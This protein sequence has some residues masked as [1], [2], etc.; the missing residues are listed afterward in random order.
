MSMKTSNIKFKDRLDVQMKDDFMRKSVAN[1]QERMFTNRAKA[2]EKLG[3]WEQWRE[4]GMD[5]RNHVLENLDYYLHQL[6][7]NVQKNGGHVFFAR[8]AEEATDYVENIVKQKNAK[9]VVKSKSMVTEEIG[10]NK[11]I[12]RNECEVVETDLGEYILQV[13]D[14]DPPSHIVVPALHKNR[15]Q[16]RDVF[17]DKIG[18]DGSDDPEELTRYVRNY[19]RHDFLE[20]DIGITGCNFAVAESGTV[21]LVTN[22]G[23][24]RLATSLP[25]THIAVMGMERIVP[26]FEELDIVVSL[27]CRS[28]VGL[29]LTGYV[30]ALTG[31]REDEHC[32]G[33]EEFHLV[34]IDNGRSDILGSEF[35]DILRCVRCA[36]CVNTCPAYRHIGGQSYGSI[37]S[38]PIGAVLSPLLGGYDDFKDLPYAC[39]L[40][41]ACH[42]VCPVK[43]PLSDLLLKHRQ[44]MAESK[45]T[46]LMERATVGAFNFINARPLL[47][48]TTV[49]VGATVASGL[50]RNGKLPV[51]V[52]VSAWT[53]SRDLPDPDG[54]S[55][56][57]WF[58]N[59]KG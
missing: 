31:P 41:R 5:I 37:Y 48:D 47:W 16:I 56:R 44:K 7:E 23:N 27:L 54:Q 39:S 43:I 52:G 17:K 2:A 40:C 4:M 58:K 1:A 20:A 24:A 14:C 42:D 26:S 35:R 15:M 34:I 32:D 19:I 10:L 21:T 30:T 36:A 29:P 45:Q 11:I 57:S 51:N 53:E 6:S 3:N 9:K 25:K 18:Y 49:K 12:E 50:I 22:E 46:P 33:P 8:T 59:R 55:F 13:D 38:G 28:A